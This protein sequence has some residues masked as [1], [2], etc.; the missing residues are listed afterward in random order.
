MYIAERHGTRLVKVNPAGELTLVAGV[1]GASAVAVGADGNLFVS[2]TRNHRVRRV[3]T[4]GNVETVAGTGEA[5]FS[6]DHGPAKQAQLNEPGGLAVDRDGNLYVHDFL[7][8]RI[9]RVGPDGTITTV[10]GT[11][12]P[13]FSADGTAAAE[14]SLGN[15]DDPFPVGF[16]FDSSGTLYFTD[17]GNHR[18]RLIDE[19]G[20]VQTVAGNGRI[21]SDGD[22]GPAIE[23]GLQGPL[24]V[25]IGPEGDIFIS[26]HGHGSA[27]DQRIRTVD[28]EGVITTLAGRGD[29]GYSGDAGPASR[30]QLNI[31]CGLAIGPD[32][33]LYI[34]DADNNVIRM[35]QLKP[36][37]PAQE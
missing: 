19:Q 35:V 11:G 15:A 10:A 36:S 2:D 37:S 16:D 6:G 34:A 33:N 27:T 25:A 22:Q 8:Y 31:P 1:D 13:G 26:S 9:R 24:D 29:A 20:R 4:M 23:A 17:Q 21:D 30:A 18:V 32:Y 7:N 3:D 12:L 28:A 5:G 14:A